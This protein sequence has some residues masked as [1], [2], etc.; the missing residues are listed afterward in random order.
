MSNSEVFLEI[1]KKDLKAAQCLYKA[2]L[3]PQAIFFLQ[4]S[5]EKMMKAF[6]SLSS[7]LPLDILK[8]K[9]GHHPFMVFILSLQ[10]FVKTFEMKSG[11]SSTDAISEVF[12]QDRDDF[13]SEVQK[14]D[15]VYR[16]LERIDGLALFVLRANLQK[17]L[18]HIHNYDAK[19]E[20]DPETEVFIEYATN[21]LKQR[22]GKDYAA[23]I[24]VID[25]ILKKYLHNI[26]QIMGPLAFL[27][28]VLPASCVQN[29]RY[30]SDASTPLDIYVKDHPL[31][32][33][34]EAI[35]EICLFV[36][37]HMMNM[38]EMFKEIEE[39]GDQLGST[40]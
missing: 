34:F 23:H 10:Q 37:E 16:K 18:D 38:S 12:Q 19:M 25:L 6:G 2:K 31:I 26:V 35:T 33:A 21:F 8:S 4:Q 11:V 5:V 27:I 40:G 7:D 20:L 32:K 36:S 15:E 29:T 17:M 28:L 13:M 1:A 3:Y 22:F 9:V 30:P 39:I 14:A 24:E